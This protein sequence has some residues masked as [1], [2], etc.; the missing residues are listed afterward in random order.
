[1]RRFLTAAAVAV[2]LAV[3]GAGYYLSQGHAKAKP[4][5]A[6]AAADPSLPFSQREVRRAFRDFADEFDYQLRNSDPADLERLE[7]AWRKQKYDELLQAIDGTLED[8]EEDIEQVADALYERFGCDSFSSSPK[9]A[10]EVPWRNP[11]AMEKNER[12]GR[13]RYKESIF[14]FRTVAHASSPSS[15]DVEGLEQELERLR[16]D[17]ARVDQPDVNSPDATLFD[18]AASARYHEKC[19]GNDG[20]GA[21][22]VYREAEV[23]DR[24]GDCDNATRLYREIGDAPAYLDSVRRCFPADADPTSPESRNAVSAKTADAFFDVVRELPEDELAIAASDVSFYDYYSYDHGREGLPPEYA[25]WMEACTANRTQHGRRS[26]AMAACLADITF[27]KAGWYEGFEDQVEH[28]AQ[29]IGAHGEARCH[30]E[31]AREYTRQ[32]RSPTASMDQRMNATAESYRRCM[33]REQ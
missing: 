20:N 14:G 33:E 31:A 17:P 15:S 26:D 6:A 18:I 22:A 4:A 10:R 5:P 19:L 16:A 11:A 8:R 12:L 3:C 21:F 7:A 27:T 23:A 28:L 9:Y 24:A 1:M 13:I 32:V 30:V 25:R 2:G 29:G